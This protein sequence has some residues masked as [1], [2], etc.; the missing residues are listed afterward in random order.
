VSSTSASTSATSSLLSSLATYGNSSSTP[1]FNIGGLASGLDTNSIIAQLMKI[2]QL[3][4]QRIIDK[5]TYETQR[6]TDLQAIQTQLG[7]LQTAVYALTNPSTWTTSQTITSS[8]PT[9]VTASGIGVPPG[10]FTVSVSQLARAAQ[11]TQSTSLTAASAADTLTI[12]VGTDPSKAFDVSVAS[13]ASLDTIAAAINTASSA[14]GGQISATVYN[15]QLVLAAQAT[16]ST[17]TI[18]VTSTGT[19]ATDLGFTQTVAPQDA[20]YSVDGGATQ[21]SSSNSITNIATGLTVTLLGTT[22]S[23]ATVTVSG[24]GANTSGVTT[25]LQN[26]VTTYNATIDMI[27]AKVNE[28]PVPNPQ[29]AADKLKGDLNGDPALESLLSRLRQSVGDLFTN[30]PASMK[31]LAQA[32]L[33]TGAAVGTGTLNQSSINGD[34]TLDTTTLQNALSSSFQDVKNLFTNATGSYDSEGLGQRLNT[35]LLQYT[36]TN[37]VL[38]SALASES[39]LLT[40]LAQQKAD[41]DVRLATRQQTLQAQFTNMETAMQKAQAQG[42]WLASQVS[43]LPKIGG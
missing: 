18:S 40:E 29:N 43:S 20:Q 31:T 4:Q 26:F 32:G 12:Q 13:G 2:E 8:D 28:Q 16:G 25:A 1:T 27:S 38:P 15:S 42:S 7:A 35:L 33:S 34:L 6:Q 5:Q 41:W 17:N 11:V 37:G 9:H 30:G 36:G 3:P 24:A 19:L 14:N 39:S 10:G 23:P 22:S 21:T